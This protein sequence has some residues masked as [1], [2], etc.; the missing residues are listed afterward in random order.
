MDADTTATVTIIVKTKKAGTLSNTASVASPEDIVL[1]NNS[2]TATTTVEQGAGQAQEA[3]E[4]EGKA[5][6]RRPDHR[7]DRRAMT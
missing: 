7:R 3:E 4:A 1:A 6:L 2:A 5:E